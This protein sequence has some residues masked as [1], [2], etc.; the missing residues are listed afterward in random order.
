VR[1]VLVVSEVALSL[2]LLIGAGLMT[3]SFMRVQQID[4]GLKVDRLVTMQINSPSLRYPD[5]ARIIAFYQRLIDSVQAAPGVEAAA[6]TSA[7]PLGGGGFYLGRVFL[8]EGQ[9]EPPA[10]TDNPAQWN[11]ISPGYFT[12]AGMTLIK[13]RDFDQRDR[14]D[15]NQVIIINQT[16]AERMFANEDPLGK[17]IRS[18][19]DENK[20]R[21]IVGVVQDVRYFGRD[22]DL[23][24]LVYVPHTQSVW[25]SMAL[26][27]RTHIDPAGV[28]SAIRGQIAAVDKELAVANLETMTTILDRSVAPRRASMLF[29]VAFG[30]IAALLGVIGIYGVL[31]YTVAQRAQEIGVRIALGAQSGDVLRLVIGHGLKLTLT[32]VGIGLVTAYAL[33]RLM[34]SLL[35]SV[36]ATD[37]MTF[38][39]VSVLL[40]GVALGACFV[41][42]SRATKVDPMVALRYE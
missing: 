21:E 23:H 37:A 13:G 31:S 8:E 20:L 5:E 38:I 41:P 40:T 30:L 18:W 16:L 11:V 35:Y 3:R 19:R 24:G 28:T 34:A 1:N 36:S 6:I 42:A 7:L 14:A 29:F 22:D 9:P 33:T 4:P 26:T 15:S 27:V 32:G 10:S 2:V 25:R 39:A 17:R 12:T